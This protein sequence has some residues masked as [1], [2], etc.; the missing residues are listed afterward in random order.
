MLYE[1]VNSILTQCRDVPEVLDLPQPNSAR[2]SS[3]GSV[4]AVMGRANAKSQKTED[5]DVLGLI[6][7]LQGRTVMTQAR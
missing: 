4:I 3:M 1:L 6:P 7:F 2:A 5:P